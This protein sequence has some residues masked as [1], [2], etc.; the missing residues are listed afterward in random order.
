MND[1]LNSLWGW[2]LALLRLGS[3]MADE[4]FRGST[5]RNVVSGRGARGYGTAEQSP[6]SG[7]ANSSRAA[8]SPGPGYAGVGDVIRQPSA[9]DTPV[10]HGR[11][12]TSSFAVLGE[13]LAAG[14]GDFS[15]YDDAQRYSF[16]AQ[17]ARQM[18]T[19]FVQPVIQPPGVGDMPG[20]AKWSVVTPSPLQS[21]VLDQIPP[22]PPANLSVPGFTVADAI[23]MRPLEPLVD[24]A[25]GKQTLANLILGLNSIAYGAPKPWPTQLEAALQLKPT[26]VLI[27]LG[28]TEALEAA[29]NGDPARF[30]DVSSFGGDYLKLLQEL[31]MARA[32]VVLLTIPD[33]LDTAYFSTIQTAGPIVK[34]EPQLLRELWHLPADALIT[35]N[36][37]NEISYQL[38]AASIGPSTGDA[39][40]TL[41]S[42]ATL[43]ADVA[44]HL[45][46]GIRQLNQQIADIGAATGAV[47]YDL[48]AFFRRIHD[49][50][51][52]IGNRTIAGDYLGGFY[53]LNGYYPGATGQAAIANEILDLLNRKFGASFPA[54]DL[55]TVMALDPV[56]AYQKAA[57][58]NWTRKDLTSPQPLPLPPPPAS[59]PPLP[60]PQQAVSQVID[61]ESH[62]LRLPPGLEQVLPIDPDGSYFGDALS[63][64]NCRTPET[65]QWASCGALYF[66]GLA[67]MDSHLSG[68]IRI[69]FTP[70]VNDWTTFQVSFERGLIGTDAYLAAPAFFVMPGK[71]QLVGDVPGFVSSG[72]LNVRTGQVDHSPGALNIYVN[73]F[74]SALFALLRVNPNFPTLPLSFPGPYGS[75]TLRFEQR[76]DGKLDFI[77][78][79][80]TFVPLGAGTAFPLNFSGPSRQFATIP[81]S[82][83]ALHPRLSLT[84]QAAPAEQCTAAAEIPFNTVQEFTLFSPASS[85]GDLFTLLACQLGGHGLGRSR[86]LGRLQIQFG[87][88]SRN[89]VPVAVSSTAAGGLLAPLSPTP[90]Q[91]L[92]PGRLSPGPEGFYESLRFPLRT[93][94]LNDLS[95]IDDPFDLSVGAIDLRTGQTLQPLLNRGFINQDLLFA[96]LR[97]EPRTPKASFF[98]RGP[99]SLKRGCAGQVF[100]F[101]GQVHIPYDASYFGNSS[102][103][104][105]PLLFPDP[106]LTTGFPVTGGGSLDPYLWLWAVQHSGNPDFVATGGCDRAVSSLGQIF[107]YRFV[108]PGSSSAT[109]AIFEYQNFSQEG[110]FQMHSLAWIDFG[111]SSGGAGIDTV[112]F[113]GFG[114]WSKDGVEEITQAAGQFYESAEAR[115]VGIQVG[116]GG[117]IS[118]VNFVSPLT[119][120]PLENIG[121]SSYEQADP[122]SST[123][124]TIAKE[125]G[126]MYSHIIELTAKPGQAK[127]LV[128]IIRDRAIPEIIRASPGFVDEIILLSDNDPNHVSAISFW[129]SKQDGDNFFQSG[130]A[131]VSAMTQPYLNAKPERGGFVVGASTNGNIV[132]WK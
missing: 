72:R 39:I 106:N 81:A 124:N 42:G 116:P 94:S 103:N 33:P 80:S 48:N 12:D 14:M 13:G 35:A 8:G 29:V 27:E 87:P 15:L 49:R 96:L 55:S 24:R 79:G 120:F 62:V 68:N 114:V 86:L 63:A 74:N 16:P 64:Q 30:P 22:S 54:I 111:N 119:A 56:A 11:L 78:Y 73:F 126:P 41:S 36:G 61:T 97:V 75:A 113:S 69:K 43:A 25:N 47:V 57:G 52:P 60:P 101:F 91:Q 127:A 4:L 82:G 58:P 109:Q 100:N 131:Q 130:F 67:M 37:L 23:R 105:P 84:T 38:Y 10:K 115:Y 122:T 3:Q 85:F 17:I 89:S 132:G 19:P 32:E 88:P 110:M 104:Q 92:F 46:S 9:T 28:F 70:P 99:A 129:K 108:L 21:T 26:L 66:R 77:F 93:Y 45:R 71:Q 50:G 121:A 2:P 125:Q 95:V 5:Q 34:L 51:F 98:F 90:L 59:R 76:P 117:E 102:P 20:F 118:N 53:S 31:R 7:A 1:S 83:T 6:S 18:R 128:D 65:I 123:G 107:S 40:S 44:T 112:T